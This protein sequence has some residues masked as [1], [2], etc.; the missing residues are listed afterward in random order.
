V[1]DL[2]KYDA[3]ANLVGP[4]TTFILTDNEAYTLFYRYYSGFSPRKYPIA[5]IDCPRRFLFICRAGC[6]GCGQ[7]R[8]ARYGLVHWDPNVALPQERGW[9]GGFH[10]EKRHRKTV[11]S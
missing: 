8:T 5:L 10:H 2:N 6:T 3:N 9:L 7:G 11:R 4:S 1:V